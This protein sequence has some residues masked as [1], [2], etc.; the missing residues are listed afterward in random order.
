[1][2]QDTQ[3]GLVEPGHIE[4]DLPVDDV[5]QSD[6]YSAVTEKNAYEEGAYGI[7]DYENSK[8]DQ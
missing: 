3:L 6:Q 8:N 5:E 1:M 4:H 2:H 7:D